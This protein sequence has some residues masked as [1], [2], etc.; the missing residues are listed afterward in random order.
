[1]RVFQNKDSWVIED[2]FDCSLVEEIKTI[3]QDNLNTLYKN[4][5]GYSTT[6]KNSEQYWL[7]HQKDNFFVNDSRFYEF[8][9][10]YKK[11]ILNRIKAADLFDE[12]K[13]ED[14]DLNH[15]NAWSVIGEENSYHTMH[16][17]NEGN[18]DGISTLVY[19]EVPETNVEDEPENDLFLA[20]HVGPKNPYYYENTPTLDINPEVGKLLIFPDWVLHGTYPQT[21]GIR[22]TFNIDYRIVPANKKD[23]SK[24][25]TYAYD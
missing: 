2:Y 19:L 7:I 25:F 9:K 1:M 16:C 5:E 11:Q 15:I 12:K 18:F 17:H 14:I 23:K 21:K 20:T 6:G 3:I 8:E 24:N 22:Q 4:K 10:E 13:K